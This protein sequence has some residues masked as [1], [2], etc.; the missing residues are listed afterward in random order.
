MKKYSDI[1]KRNNMQNI[2]RLIEQIINAFGIIIQQSLKF[3]LNIWQKTGF[4]LQN[5]KKVLIRKK[6]SFLSN[7][8]AF[9]PRYQKNSDHN[10]SS[11]LLNRPSETKSDL[12]QTQS[13][14]QEEYQYDQ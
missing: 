4:E 13:D 1:F 6:S 7:D 10:I 2:L 5:T 11:D 8:S 9:V 3:T 12:L 14:A